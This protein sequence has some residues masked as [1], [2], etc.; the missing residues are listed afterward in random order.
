VGVIDVYL[1]PQ[2]GITYM[3]RQLGVTEKLRW[4]VFSPRLYFFASARNGKEW[5]SWY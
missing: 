5:K 2:E 1:T 4:F 3:A